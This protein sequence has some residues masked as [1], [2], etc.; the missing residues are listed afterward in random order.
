MLI[1][2]LRE[3][4][5]KKYNISVIF[6]VILGAVPQLTFETRCF[7]QISHDLEIVEKEN[8]ILCL[9]E[10]RKNDLKKVFLDQIRTNTKIKK[11]TQWSKIVLACF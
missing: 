1:R 11:N 2:W 8:K 6:L 4:H 5:V 7:R 3:H 10:N 9:S